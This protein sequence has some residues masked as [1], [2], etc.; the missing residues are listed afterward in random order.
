MVVDQHDPV[1]L[2]MLS[3]HDSATEHVHQIPFKQATIGQLT[4]S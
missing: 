3:Q 1:M 4:T 2:V